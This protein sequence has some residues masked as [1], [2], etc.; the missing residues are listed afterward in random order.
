M[1]NIDPKDEDAV[2]ARAD[3]IRAERAAAA[4]ASKREQFAPLLAIVEGKAF[5]AVRDDLDAAKDALIT[6]PMIYQ[7]VQALVQLLNSIPAQIPADAR[8]A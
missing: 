6:S 3:E 7:S 8:T 4:L 2:L 5:R 1:A